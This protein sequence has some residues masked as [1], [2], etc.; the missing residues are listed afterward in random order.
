MAQVTA[1]WLTTYLR[2]N[3]LQLPHPSSA[4]SGGS[5]G[6]RTPV[7]IGLPF[8]R[9]HAVNTFLTL[10]A[11]GG[12]AKWRHANW[13]VPGSGGMIN[14]LEFC[15]GGAPPARWFWQLEPR[16]AALDPAYAWG[17]WALQGAARAG[18]VGLPA[19]E[20][21]PLSDPF[22]I[23]RWMSQVLSGGETPHLWTYASSAL[24]VW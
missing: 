12:A 14:V 20:H 7:P 2:A 22:P 1:G 15:L 16:E 4:A 23:V 11:H 3:W 13:G 24:R 17:S 21:V 6:R 5:R 8:I 10:G 9:D 19:P 18:G